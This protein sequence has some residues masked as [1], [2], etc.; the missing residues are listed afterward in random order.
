M[1]V[2]TYYRSE[3]GADEFARNRKLYLSESMLL[4]TSQI[5]VAN[6]WMRTA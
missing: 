1:L 6:D 5:A 2:P 3:K 4:K